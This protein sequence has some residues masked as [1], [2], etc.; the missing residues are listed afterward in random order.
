MKSKN[1]YILNVYSFHDIIRKKELEFTCQNP[2]Y[3]FVWTNVV[4]G[5]SSEMAID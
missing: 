5:T 3:G 2:V 4:D 1:C